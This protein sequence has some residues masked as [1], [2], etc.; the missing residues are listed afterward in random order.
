[1]IIYEYPLALIT[2][3]RL[4]PERHIRR[5]LILLFQYTYQITETTYSRYWIEGFSVVIGNG[6]S[7]V[8]ACRSAL[9]RYIGYEPR[10]RHHK[11]TMS[12]GLVGKEDLIA[13]DQSQI[14]TLN[15]LHSNS[16]SVLHYRKI[17]SQLPFSRMLLN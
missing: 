5:M 11:S 13:A 3:E 10:R 16:R 4:I 8:R 6:D 7:G 1:M 15:S 12:V 9:T 14:D 17:S 2:I